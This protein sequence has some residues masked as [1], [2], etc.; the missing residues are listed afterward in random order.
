MLRVS[1]VVGNPKPASRTRQ[2]SE[3]VV[4]SLIDPRLC[5]VRSFDLA[6]YVSEIF[7]WPSERM[8]VVSETVATSDLAV[9][10]SPTYKASYTGLLK[11]FLDRYPAGGLDGV[12]AIPVM[13]GADLS[14]S[15]APE[16]HLRPLLIELGASV[17]TSALYF[18]TS[19]MDR[20]DCVVEKWA[21]VSRGVFSQ[22]A[23][24]GEVVESSRS[25][26]VSAK[27]GP[28]P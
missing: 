9:F 21:E 16:T 3:A 25:T 28:R 20:M 11:S 26:T 7:E 1:V 14:H 12:I 8:S 24:L 23:R 17:P 27:P 4:R 15:V 22:L 18:V 10:A 2:I 19:Q 6:D 13:T 5:T